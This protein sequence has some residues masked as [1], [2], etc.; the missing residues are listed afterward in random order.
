M[1][2]LKP[3]EGEELWLTLRDRHGGLWELKH[4]ETEQPEPLQSTVLKLHHQDFD[5]RVELGLEP[6]DQLVQRWNSGLQTHENQRDEGGREGLRLQLVKVKSG[7]SLQTPG[8]DQEELGVS[9]RSRAVGVCRR[10][11]GCVTD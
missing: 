4:H 11:G 9:H 2:K 3:T 8:A 6:S 10:P 1:L 7:P 5:L